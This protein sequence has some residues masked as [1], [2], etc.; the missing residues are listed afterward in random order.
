MN[1]LKK[2][3]TPKPDYKSYDFGVLFFC[4]KQR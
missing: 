2:I 1:M 3:K 4:F